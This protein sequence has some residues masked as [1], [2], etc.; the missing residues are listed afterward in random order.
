MNQ[1]RIILRSRGGDHAPL[2]RSEPVRLGVPFARGAVRDVD[3][4]SIHDALGS[5]VAVQWRVLER[6]P[7]GSLRW[8]LADWQAT[9]GGAPDAHYELRVGHAASAVMPSRPIALD[10]TDGVVIVDTGAAT[11]RMAVGAPLPFADVTMNGRTRIDAASSGLALTDATGK[12]R[13][14]TT[15]RLSVEETG[16]LRVTVRAEA[17]VPG[18]E[19][20]QISVRMEFFAGLPTTQMSVTLWNSRRAAHPG[21]IWVLGDSGSIVFRECSLDFVLPEATAASLASLSLQ[22]G[23]ALTA[24][25]TTFDLSQESSGGDAWQSSN[26]VTRDGVVPAMHRGYRL[27]AAE[28]TEMAGLRA[29]P[30]GCLASGADSVALA[31][32][33]FWQNFP[34][35]LSGAA[36][37]LRLS[38]FPGAETLHELQGGERK[39]HA[40][41]VSFGSDE[42][43]DPALDWTRDPLVPCLPAEWYAQADP[44][45]MLPLDAPLID[46]AA[47]Y[48]A[49]VQHGI[50]GPEAFTAKAERIDEYGWRNYG[51]LFADHE[52]VGHAGRSVSISHYN[53]QYDAVAGFALQ[54]MRG[55]D[56]RWRRL[57]LD[58][59][60]HVCDI[61]IYHTS[62]DKAAFN[63]GLFWHTA[64]YTDAATSTHRSFP[65]LPGVSGGGPSNEHCY[66]VGLL[67]H[68]LMTGDPVSREVVL[69]LAQWV[70]DIDDGSKTVFKWLA[71]GAT[72]LAS[73]TADTSYHGPGRG[74]GN[75]IQALLNA[76]RLDPAGPWLVEAEALI[77]RCIHPADDIEGRNLLDAERRWSY[78]VFLQVLVR[79]L[80][81]KHELGQDDDAAAYA[82]A[83]FLAY[84]RWMRAHEYPYLDKPEILEFPNETWSAQDIRKAEVF[85]AAAAL[86]PPDE[87]E[88]FRQRGDFFFDHSVRALEA[89]GSA[90]LTRPMVLL[91]TQGM[92]A[93]A[94]RDVRVRWPAISALHPAGYA[95]PARM[96]F[97]PQKVRALRRARL[98]AV[99]LAG[100][101]VLCAGAAVWMVF[102]GGL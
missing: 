23:E 82:A 94:A 98:V 77:R 86:G 15:N 1:V 67:L 26:H 37:Q 65:R 29:T 75:A 41:F 74:A 22:P 31:V 13:R 25:G 5:A 95:A 24:M 80:E 57:M 76:D 18:I 10:A 81:R 34:K 73:S 96:D 4:C 8:G 36:R 45:L 102:A 66:S 99:S 6:W 69:T 58:L 50:E 42:V 44:S 39:T 79:Y 87:T 7:D 85:Y 55:A 60:A 72:G 97:E 11:F 28:S 93:R 84:A 61:D 12:T 21:G 19:S 63:G 91:T 70:L 46:T 27:S 56:L 47:T 83:S 78:T 49:L 33:L 100:M 68:H 38:L 43:S 48:D 59:A 54:F 30:V 92:R 89:S 101:A 20:L 2:R 64:H 40:C 71:R 62:E 52:A 53:N 51:D 14:V 35:A 3:A 32:P 9:T 88:G 16:P 90:T 17:L